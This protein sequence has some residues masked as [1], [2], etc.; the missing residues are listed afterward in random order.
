MEPHLQLAFAIQSQPGVYA[1]LLGSGVSRA[2]G[3]PT[4]WEVTVELANQLA[5]ATTDTKPTDIAA[6]YRET[7]QQPISYSDVV[8]RGANTQAERRKLLEPFFEPNDVEREQGKKSPTKAH[9]AIA[10]LVA[11]GFVRVIITTNFDR[12][13]ERA[14]DELAIVP[15]VIHTIDA[16]NGASPLVHSRCTI[17]KLHGDYKD[18]RI[19]NTEIELQQYEPA[20]NAL[21][22]RVL[23]EY[24]LIVCGW[25]TDSDVALCDAISRAPNRRY[26]TY[27]A[28]RGAPTPTAQNLINAR[29]AQIIIINEADDFFENLQHKVVAIVELKQAHPDS[30]AVAVAEVKRLVAEPRFRVR[31]NDLV[32]EETQR[33][34]AECREVIR[35]APLTPQTLE[36]TGRKI[37]IHLAMLIAMLAKGVRWGGAEHHNTWEAVLDC[38]S[39]DPAK[40]DVQSATLTVLD[41]LPAAIGFYGMGITAL[42]RNDLILLRKL[43][44]VKLRQLSDSE[45]HPRAIDCLLAGSL[46]YVRQNDF[47]QGF[48]PNERKHYPLSDWLFDGLWPVFERVFNDKKAFEQVFDRFELTMAA[49]FRFHGDLGDGNDSFWIP[50]GAFGYRG[51]NRKTVL[52]ELR[53]SLEQDGNQSPYIESRLVES[54]VSRILGW[55]P[56]FEK[57]LKD[58]SKSW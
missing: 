7:Y 8:A 38:L 29:K 25:S 53:Y 46:Q 23:D 19:K 37:R 42:V 24:G 45:T 56:E 21:L 51:T 55:L 52:A 32:I 1:L 2:A 58:F 39:N 33:A 13:L 6:W 28:S 31:L 35:A 36:P 43:S 47:F 4:G 22:D 54:E 12:L 10:Q 41:R 5:I 50:F 27:W 18:A 57:F 15:D 16:L 48:F 49:A 14:L 11:A 30:A 40:T 26:S 34:I 9:R 17:I 20:W 3:I 44:C